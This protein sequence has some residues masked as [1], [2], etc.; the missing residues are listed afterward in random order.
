VTIVRIEEEVNKSWAAENKLHA[1]K[2]RGRK[3]AIKNE[4]IYNNQPQVQDR[5]KDVGGLGNT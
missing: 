2:P 5:M 3:E 4:K 1:N